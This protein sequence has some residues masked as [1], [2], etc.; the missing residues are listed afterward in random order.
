MKNLNIF[1]HKLKFIKPAQESGIDVRPPWNIFLLI[2]IILFSGACWLSYIIFDFTTE[3]KA[4]VYVPVVTKSPNVD[5]EK[6]NKVLEFFSGRETY[7]QNLVIT[8][9]VFID[10]SK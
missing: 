10:P 6:S 2:F 5:S 1:K 7:L 8:K 9:T 4:G 3:D